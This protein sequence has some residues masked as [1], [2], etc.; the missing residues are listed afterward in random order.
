[1]RLDIVLARQKAQH[2]APVP[3]G[4]E[5]ALRLI[6]ARGRLQHQQHH[7]QVRVDVE[8]GQ[9]RVFFKNFYPPRARDVEHLAV[10][11]VAVRQCLERLAVD[12]FIRHDPQHQPGVPVQV[13]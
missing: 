1:M 4:L 10:G 12:R 7:A 5:L 11:V 13:A 3:E 2:I 9:R 6:L 8:P